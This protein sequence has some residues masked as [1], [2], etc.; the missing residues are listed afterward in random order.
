[1][2]TAITITPD[3]SALS[4]Y[5]ASRPRPPNIVNDDFLGSFA[6]LLD[7]I[8]PLQHIPVIS[9]IYRGLTGDTLSAGAQI[10]GG[11]LF[12]GPIGLIASIAG[13]IIEQ[14]T[15]K[16][17]AANVFAAVTGQYEKTATL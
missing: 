8:N 13:S 1:M 14:Q 2:T 4:P 17:I 15:G 3:S 7:T 9:N 10:I 11:A 6:D 16:D 12:G 5:Q